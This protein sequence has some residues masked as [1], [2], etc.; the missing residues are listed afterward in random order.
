PLQL[1]PLKQHYLALVVAHGLRPVTALV[2]LLGCGKDLSTEQ[3]L[4]IEGALLQDEPIR[5][6]TLPQ[7]QALLESWESNLTAAAKPSHGRRR[8]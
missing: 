6:E 8:T 3:Q 2:Q 1:E 7:L 5:L 4:E